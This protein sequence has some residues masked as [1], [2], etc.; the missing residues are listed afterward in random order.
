M[1]ENKIKE[2]VYDNCLLYVRY[3][4]DKQHFEVFFHRNTLDQ[5]LDKDKLEG[6]KDILKNTIEEIDEY[7]ARW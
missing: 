6:F 1:E 5:D 2:L 4:A 3:N 7:I